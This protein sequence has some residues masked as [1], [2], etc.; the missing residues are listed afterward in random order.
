VQ[1]EVGLLQPAEICAPDELPKKLFRFVD[2]KVKRAVKTLAKAQQASE[3]GKA[4]RMQKQLN[5]FAKLITA[6]QQKTGEF[7][8]EGL[9]APC[10]AKVDGIAT[11]LTT[12]VEAMSI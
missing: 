7:V 10:A 6:I 3:A 8:E 9:S 1:C 2:K 4:E 11:E 5:R 12:F